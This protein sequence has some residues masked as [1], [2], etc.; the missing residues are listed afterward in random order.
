MFLLSS[1]AEL[2][3]PPREG[4]GGRAAVGGQR[5]PVAGVVD[6]VGSSGGAGSGWVGVVGGGREA[7]LVARGSPKWPMQSQHLRQL[8][9][10]I[11]HPP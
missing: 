10:C 2:P 5:E 11:T 1:T 7:S 3:P 9:G 4:S 8:Q 6:P